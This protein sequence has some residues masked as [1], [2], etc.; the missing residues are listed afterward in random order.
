MTLCTAL[1][2]SGLSSWNTREDACGIGRGTKNLRN[3]LRDFTLPVR[4][5]KEIE[6]GRGAIHLAKIGKAVGSQI[7][8]LV[9][10]KPVAKIRHLNDDRRNVEGEYT[11]TVDYVMARARHDALFRR[12]VVGEHAQP[13]KRGYRHGP[14]NHDLRYMFADEPPNVDIDHRPSPEIGVPTDKLHIF[15]GDLCPRDRCRGHHS[16]PVR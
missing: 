5:G 6:A 2:S 14:R 16:H 12:N 1:L 8:G 9:D 4:P 3:S 7:N 13:V 15:F 10:P 11:R